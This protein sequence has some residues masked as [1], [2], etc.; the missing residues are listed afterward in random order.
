MSVAHTGLIVFSVPF[1]RATCYI[2]EKTELL[3]FRKI[4]NIKPSL[5]FL[6]VFS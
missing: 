6:C 3:T 4:I 2:G 5:R 1:D